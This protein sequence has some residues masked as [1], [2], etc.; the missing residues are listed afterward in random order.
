M[1]KRE[2]S[3]I[4]DILYVFTATRIEKRRMILT[5][6]RFAPLVTSILAETSPRSY[7]ILVSRLLGISNNEWWSEANNALHVLIVF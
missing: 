4:S 2:G 6:S 5:A 1:K 7:D 3:E